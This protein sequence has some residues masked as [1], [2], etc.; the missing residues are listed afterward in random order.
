[1]KKSVTVMISLSIIVITVL[2]GYLVYIISADGETKIAEGAAKSYTYEPGE[3]F[4]TNI[5][6]SRRFL[7][8][9]IVLEVN[10][11]KYLSEMQENNHK[12]RDCVIGILR[13]KSEDDIVM[14]NSEGLLKDE[15]MTRLN[16][17]LNIKVVNVY[18]NEF[19]VQ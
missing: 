4:I 14:D 1:M 13:C 10:N 18:F 9:A 12:I 15:I 7:K 8:A 3:H 11:K 16:N 5:K 2:L 6:G 17:A 19:V